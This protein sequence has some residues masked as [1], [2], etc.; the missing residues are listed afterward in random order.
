[1]S[2]EP[3]DAE[4]QSF[5]DHGYL[6]LPCRFGADDVRR[7][8]DEADRILELC[9]NSSLANQRKSGRLNIIQRPGG[10]QVVRRIQ[11]IIDLSLPLHQFS[12]DPRLLDPLR[13]LLGGE[14]ALMEEKITYKEPLP[15]PVQ[16]LPCEEDMDDRFVVHSDWAYYKDQ[17]YPKGLISTAVCLDD[18][19]EASGPLRV[20]PG[21]HL[22]HREHERTPFGRQVL[23][24]LLDLHGGEDVLAP[25]GSMIL[26]HAM[27]VHS[28]RPN[29]SGRPRRLMIYSHYLADAGLGF[30][31]RNGP[32]RLAESPWEWRYQ[33]LK[34]AGAFQDVFHA[35]QFP[36]G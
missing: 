5:H 7:M 14:V 29:V 12:H 22:V 30:D 4:V 3:T 33:R 6:V 1:M 35:P 28:S 19:T 32:L 15:T 25:A 18:C 24:H 27:L 2:F 34:D 23:P 17:G 16:G 11:P 26:W 8:R 36:E 9:I 21:S 31:A 20:W 13:H 10:P